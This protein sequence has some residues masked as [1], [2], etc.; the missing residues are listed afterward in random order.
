MGRDKSQLIVQGL[1]LAVRTGELLALVA[2]TAIE[3]GPGV[4]G[5]PSILEPQR[6]EGPL[7]AV[8]AGC[9]A[10][11]EL[12][13]T[14]AALIVACDLPFL[15]EQLLRFIINWNSEESVVPVV[16]GKPQPL[17][18]KW[19]LRDLQTAQEFVNRGV[20]TLQHLSTQP[21][22]VHLDELQWGPIVDERQ[23]SDVDSPEDLLR[24]GL[25]KVLPN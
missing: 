11:R 25:T 9:A 23:F 13:H 10:L 4:S 19:S 17:C 16:R 5:L 2:E 14:G 22:V 12:G 24:L 20:R 7:V 6:G 8:A 15:S 21:G 1:T 18:A 3:V